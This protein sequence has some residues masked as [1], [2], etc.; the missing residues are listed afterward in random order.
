[1]ESVVLESVVDSVAVED[2]VST[3]KHAQTTVLFASTTTV[4]I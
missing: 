2:V 3:L 1:M 4:Q